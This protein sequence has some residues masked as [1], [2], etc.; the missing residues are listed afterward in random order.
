MARN[1]MNTRIP[2]LWKCSDFPTDEQ[3][4]KSHRMNFLMFSCWQKG[5][6]LEDILP[7]A[8][9]IHP[10]TTPE[11]VEVYFK[12]MLETEHSDKPNYLPKTVNH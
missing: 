3:I 7:L 10:T 8:Q 9:E 2:D 6:E 4:N 1:T 11:D 5:M 12:N